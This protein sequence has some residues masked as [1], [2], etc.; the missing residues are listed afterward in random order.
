[1]SKKYK[2]YQSIVTALENQEH[3]FFTRKQ[4]IEKIRKRNKIKPSSVNL[5]NFCYNRYNKGV[6]LECNLFHYAG[7]GKYEYLGADFNYTGLVYQRKKGTKGD[8]VVGDWLSGS[9]VLY[10]TGWYLF[11]EDRRKQKIESLKSLYYSS[12]YPKE[13][14]KAKPKQNAK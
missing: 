14:L 10:F 11:I 13:R 2:L 7:K 5:T 6:R 4:I 9:E 1:M 12:S 3:Q 8:V